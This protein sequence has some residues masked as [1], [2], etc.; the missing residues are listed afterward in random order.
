MLEH[1]QKQETIQ[2]KLEEYTPEQLDQLYVRVFN[3][4]DGELILKDLANRFYVDVPTVGE[5]TEGMR[6][7]YMSIVSR[8][9]NTVNK[10][11]EDKDEG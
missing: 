10:K 3:T 6:M 11:R 2:N 4:D 7:A 1:L 5:R 9:R 8:M